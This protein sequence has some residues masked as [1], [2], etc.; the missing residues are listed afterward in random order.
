MTPNPSVVDLVNHNMNSVKTVGVGHLQTERQKLTGTNININGKMTTHFGSCSYL[1]L[2]IDQ[3]LKDA[4]IEAINE[5]G[6]QFSCSRAYLSIPL[7]SELEDLLAQIFDAPTVIT[8]T[9]TLGHLANIPILVTSK[10]AVVLDHQ[11]HNS[12]QNATKIAKANGAHVEMVR[13]NNL[14]YLER[15]I[16]KLKEQYKKIWY[17]A[18]GIYSMYGDACPIKELYSLLEKHEELHLYIDDAHGMSWAGEKGKGYILDQV[19]LHPRMILVTSFCK[20]YGAS[21]GATIFPNQEMATRVRNCG[22]THIF[23]SPLQ[24]AIL[25]SAIASAKIHLSPEIKGFQDQLKKNILFFQR[26]AKQLNLP[27]VDNT[28]TPIQYI[29]AGQPAMALKLCKRLLDSGYYTCVAGYPSVPYNN[30][31]IRITIN[32]LHTR[33][34]IQG[35][36]STMSALMDEVLEEHDYTRMDILKAFKQKGSSPSRPKVS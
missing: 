13:H 36:L 22:S 15:R 3:R 24:P 14:E 4:A 28:L 20:G 2:E 30:C 17:M 12:V 29:G 7:Y 21:G 16:I 6:I 10:D 8:P 25:A 27:L 31:G 32:R 5:Y 33:Q 18:D 23:S 35:L 9:S 26:R 19:D 1:N 11:V 34:Q